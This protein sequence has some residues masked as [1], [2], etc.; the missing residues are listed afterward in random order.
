MLLH[1]L[2]WD[3]A[4]LQC[5]AIFVLAVWNK[6]I[7]TFPLFFGLVAYYPI[8]DW[9][10][11]RIQV[12][13]SDAVWAWSTS[14]LMVSLFFFELTVLYQLARRLIFSHVKLARLLTPL[15]RWTLVAVVLS[16]TIL[17][18]IAGDVTQDGVTSAFFR[19]MLW[20]DFLELFLLVVL[21]MLTGTLGIS[22]RNLPAGMALGWG[23]S[24]VFN[25]AAHAL[26]R[27]AHHIS[28]IR[29]DIIRGV[30]FN[31]CTLIW[32]WYTLRAT[33]PATSS[34]ETSAETA[35]L[36]DL[37]SRVAVLHSEVIAEAERI[38]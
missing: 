38:L 33:A 9:I 3:T 25:L 18:A 2:L 17:A 23:I 30:G 37:H 24:S 15:R 4:G 19:F 14:F 32:L 22:W 28:I 29:T 5:I 11:L 21:V 36:V 27:G 35:C 34:V 7:R 12:V 16:T 13:S 31:A 8:F 20:Q 26:V 1:R 10:F 6:R